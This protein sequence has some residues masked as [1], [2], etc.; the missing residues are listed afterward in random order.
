MKTVKIR[1]YYGKE[2]TVPVSDEVYEGLCDLRREEDR[3]RKR[4]AYRRARV[5]PEDVEA[6]LFH[7]VAENP[8]EDELIQRDESQRLYQAIEQLPPVQRRRVLMLLEDMNCLQIAQSEG[9]HPSVIYRSVERSLLR[10][11]LL[12]GG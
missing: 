9:R 1:D 10:L 12:M 6:Q 8:V 11:R 2:Q 4:I 7:H 5:T 3:L